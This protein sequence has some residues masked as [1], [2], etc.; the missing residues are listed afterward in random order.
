MPNDQYCYDDNSLYMYSGK[1][2][3]LDPPHESVTGTPWGPTNLLIEGMN[4]NFWPGLSNELQK[5]Q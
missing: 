1:L 5:I 4:G 2:T 3:V